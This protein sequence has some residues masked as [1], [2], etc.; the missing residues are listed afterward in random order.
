M[1][2][3]AVYDKQEN[4]IVMPIVNKYGWYT[5]HDYTKPMAALTAFAE[6]IEPFITAFFEEAKNIT[7]KS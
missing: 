7:L 2:S 3:K 4:R 1:I 5:K 6:R